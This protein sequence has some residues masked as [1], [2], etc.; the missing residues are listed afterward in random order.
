MKMVRERNLL[1]PFPSPS[2]ALFTPGNHDLP[3]ALPFRFPPESFLCLLPLQP[4]V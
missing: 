3:L 2:L 4:S 1:V